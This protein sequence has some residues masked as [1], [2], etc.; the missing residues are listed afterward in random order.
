MNELEIR[1]TED[2]TLNTV[3][4]DLLTQRHFFLFFCSLFLCDHDITHI[5]N[6]DVRQK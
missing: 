1:E 5:E 2:H 3:W 4:L 6:L